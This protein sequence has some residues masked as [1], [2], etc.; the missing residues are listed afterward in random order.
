[1][2]QVLKN[3]LAWLFKHGIAAGVFVG[4]FG[5]AAIL[6]FSGHWPFP[7]KS[8]D[9]RAHLSFPAGGP[10]EFLYLD[11]SRVAAYLAQIVGGTFASEEQSSKVSDTAETK[12]ALQEAV[13]LGTSTSEEHTLSRVVTP[14]AA[15]EYFELLFDL[16]HEPGRR[17]SDGVRDISISYFHRDVEGLSEG[18]FVRFQT[19]GLR[20]PIYL[21]PY[22][23]ARQRTTM[24]ALFPRSRE[25]DA[26]LEVSRQRKRIRHFRRQLGRNPRVTFKLRPLY[27]A[28][29][30]AIKARWQ[31]PVEETAGARAKAFAK[32]RVHTECRRARERRREHGENKQERRRRGKAVY[33]LP[34]DARR[35]TR[36]RSLMK[37]GGGDFTVV[38]KVVR[39]FPEHGDKLYPAYIDSFTRETWEQPLAHA[40]KKLLCRTD[41]NCRKLAL[42]KKFKEARKQIAESRCNDLAAV[43]GQTEIPMRG[44]VILPIAIYK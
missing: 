27:P 17:G 40:P 28:Q 44:A 24:Q 43:R 1:M 7:S 8:G 3:A 36:E 30:E 29:I 41:P 37:Y 32:A 20:P 35:L 16:E 38:G 31:G 39:V 42:R 26:P 21:N 14:T 33:L 10:A 12:L 11:N 4:V 25:Q 6:F 18:Q 34:L 9:R 19:H 22:L 5:I 23:A 13:Q 15:A 2:K